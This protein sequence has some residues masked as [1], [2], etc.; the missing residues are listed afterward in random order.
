MKA[1]LLRFH[2]QDRTTGLFTL[3]DDDENQ[4]FQCKTLELPDREN[5]R[6]ISCIPK[7][8]YIVIKAFSPKFGLCFRVTNVQNRDNILIH[9]G[10]FLKDTTGCILIG[11]SFSS[12][13]DLVN[14]KVTLKKLL[15]TAPDNFTMIVQ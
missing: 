2:R 3:L 8:E 14:S 4:V 9:V 1:L 7:G 13:W 12:R 5:Q 15:E 6:L 10:N 11:E